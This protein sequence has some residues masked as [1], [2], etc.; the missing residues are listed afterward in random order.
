MCHLLISLYV[1]RCA[2]VDQVWW[3]PCARHAFGKRAAAYDHRM[4]M[5]ERAVEGHPGLAV[6][7]IERSFDGPSFTIDTLAALQRR[8]PDARFRWIVGSDLLGELARWH[9]WAELSEQLSFIVVQRGPSGQ[10][11]PAQGTFQRLPLTF[12]DLSSTA[13]R[14]ALAGGQDV[15]GLVD[16][17]VRAYFVDHPELYGA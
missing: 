2:G 13:I 11:A 14:A 8:H 4:A 17:A 3:I 7:D 9:R 5:C 6:S 12:T 15:R 16:D 1:Q 10:P